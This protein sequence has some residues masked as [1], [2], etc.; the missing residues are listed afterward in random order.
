MSLFVCSFLISFV[1]LEIAVRHIFPPPPVPRN[2]PKFYNFADYKIYDIGLA[3]FDEDL[4]WVNKPDACG[5]GMFG[6]FMSF[7][8]RTFR[9]NNNGITV[10]K[11]PVILAIGDSY[12]VGVEVDNADTWPSQLELKSRIKVFNGGVGGYGLDQMLTR[13]RLVAEKQ[14]IDFIIVAFIAESITRVKQKKQFSI[15]KPNYSIRDGKLIPSKV[16]REDYPPPDYFKKIA[17]YSYVVHLLMSKICE[18]Y[19]KKGG[20]FDTEYE[21]MDEI[22]VS[23]KLIDEFANLANKNNVQ[24]LIFVVLPAFYGDLSLVNHPVTQYIRK[25]SE[26]NGRIAF[27]DIQTELLNR[28]TFG[29]QEAALRAMFNDVTRG[30]HG[31][32]SKAG[33]EFV[34][35]EI[36]SLLRRLE[37]PSGQT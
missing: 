36:F 29:D 37:R 17:G 15:M 30:Y 28:Q 2:T 5:Y 32:F 27:I 16:K 9:K 4:G 3:V 26:Q 7:D 12:T 23:C 19:W 1:L 11:S 25:S 8:S 14:K 35:Q 6:E 10:G 31:H 24:R 21:D 22:D 13:T 20:L 33:H 34:A 18:E